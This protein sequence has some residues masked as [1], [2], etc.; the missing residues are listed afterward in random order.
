MQNKSAILGLGFEAIHVEHYLVE[1]YSLFA[2]PGVTPSNRGIGTAGSS[3]CYA[4]DC[5]IPGC[6]GNGSKYSH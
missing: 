3:A 4:P 6:C 1:H 5:A 2:S